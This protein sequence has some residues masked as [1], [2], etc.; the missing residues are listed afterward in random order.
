MLIAIKGAG[1][2]ATGIACRLAVVVVGIG[3][4]DQCAAGNIVCRTAAEGNSAQMHVHVNDTF[5]IGLQVV[6]VARV[7]RA[8]TGTA[9]V[10]VMLRRAM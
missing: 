9:L 3:V 6:H 5:G 2:L 10:A 1:D 7:M 8:A 4:D